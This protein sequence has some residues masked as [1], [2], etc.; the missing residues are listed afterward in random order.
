MSPV[1]RAEEDLGQLVDAGHRRALVAG[2]H[3]LPHGRLRGRGEVRE[4]HDHVVA[5]RD[6]V[7]HVS[8]RRDLAHAGSVTT[9]ADLA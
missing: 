9:R 3:D 1:L 8:P 2:R 5:V 6:R 7:I 4:E